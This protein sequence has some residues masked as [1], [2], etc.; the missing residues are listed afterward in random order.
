MNDT[1]WLEDFNETCQAIQEDTV[2]LEALAAYPNH[3]AVFPQTLKRL[4]DYLSQH[5]GDLR[6]LE[7]RLVA[8]Q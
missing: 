6:G 1:S 7:K 3:S 8:L 5:A 2:L 4:T